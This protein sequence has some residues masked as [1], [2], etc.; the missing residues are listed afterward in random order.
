MNLLIN[1]IEIL[2]KGNKIRLLRKPG[3]AKVRRV[4]NKFT[5]EIVVLIPAKY[6]PKTNMSCTPTPVNLVLEENGVMNVQPAT[7][8]VA[9]AHFTTCLFCRF[10]NLALYTKNQNDSGN[11]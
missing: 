10:I 1:K 8:W 7:V 5:K 3:I 4:V 6:T 2:T 9:F 11:V